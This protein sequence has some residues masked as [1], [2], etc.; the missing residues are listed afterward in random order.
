MDCKEIISVSFS[1]Q[2]DEDLVETEIINYLEELGFRMC[3]H[4]RDFVPGTNIAENIANAT[5]CSH[6][7]I[8]LISRHVMHDFVSFKYIYMFSILPASMKVHDSGDGS[9]YYAD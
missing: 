9:K 3:W 8:F 1:S 5:E 6:R 2:A 4:Q 7:M